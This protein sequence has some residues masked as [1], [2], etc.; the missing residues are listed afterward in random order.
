MSEFYSVHLPAAIHRAQSLDE[1][2]RPSS[3]DDRSSLAFTNAD[4]EI[5]TDEMES[6]KYFFCS[7]YFISIR[8]VILFPKIGVMALDCSNQPGLPALDRL[9]SEESV[10]YDSSNGYVTISCFEIVRL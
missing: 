3:L 5:A 9:M 2:R 8:N 4:D 7:Q 6:G 1:M 10:A